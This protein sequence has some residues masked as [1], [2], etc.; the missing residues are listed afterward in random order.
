MGVR[1]DGC[2]TNYGYER[3]VPLGCGDGAIADLGTK[4]LRKE[5]GH[6]DQRDGGSDHE[7]PEDGSFVRNQLRSRI[8]K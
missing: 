3:A 6:N 1:V 2:A 5:E 4:S 8:D 7:K